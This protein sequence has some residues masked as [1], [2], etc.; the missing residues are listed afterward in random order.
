MVTLL[1][2]DLALIGL[3]LL[4]RRGTQWG[5]DL[6]AGLE[7]LTHYVF[8]PALLF[9]S[10]ARTPVSAATVGPLIGVVVAV[11]ALGWLLAWL[12]RPV[13]RVGTDRLASGAQCAYRFNSILVL[14]IADRAGGANAAGLAAVCVGLGVPLVNLLAV[15]GLARHSERS[16]ARELGTNP[17]LIA[18]VTAGVVAV[19][20][21]D[22]PGPIAAL[23]QRTGSAAIPL[24]LISVGAALRWGGALRE[25]RL[26]AWIIGIRALVLPAA[27]LALSPLAGVGSDGQALMAFA[28]APTATASYILTSRMG[29]DGP[30]VAILVS[31][32]TVV[33]AVTAP[34]WLALVMR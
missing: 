4:L 34:M 13:L 9:L 27:V 19:A 14:A 24:G 10:I 7:R 22:L 15:L 32:S 33:G 3:G 28:G 11:V 30:F 29:G 26:V 20:G 16:L 21:I 6:W 25:P 8:L 31:L 5:D 18:T 23:L 12:A 17:L 1:L 2:P